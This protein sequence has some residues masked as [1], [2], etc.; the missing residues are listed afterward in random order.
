MT[1]PWKGHMPQQGIGIL[2]FSTWDKCANEVEQRLSTQHK[3]LRRIEGSDQKDTQR[4]KNSSA[5]EGLNISNEQGKRQNLH[6]L[7]YQV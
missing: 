7:S 5:S 1:M 2:G 3:T 4:T 6:S